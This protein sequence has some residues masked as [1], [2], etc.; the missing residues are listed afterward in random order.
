MIIN[1]APIDINISAK[2]KT[3]QIFRSIKS[4]IHPKNMR[5]MLL[6][7]AP[8]RIRRRQKVKVLSGFLKIK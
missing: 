4:I 2:L 8:A 6:A 5:S 1:I 7:S 3:G